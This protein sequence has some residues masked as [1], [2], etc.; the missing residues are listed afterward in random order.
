M[1]VW[2]IYSLCGMILILLSIIN[3][4][5]DNTIRNLWIIY[6]FSGALIGGFL[7]GLNIWTLYGMLAVIIILYGM[8]G[9]PKGNILRNMWIFY[10]ISGFLLGLM[11]KD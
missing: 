10:I 9:K 6:I 7:N 2:S 1:D 3:K 8:L 4:F 5:K 11:L